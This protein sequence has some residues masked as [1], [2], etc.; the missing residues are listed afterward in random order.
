[1]RLRIGVKDALYGLEKVLL[2][3]YVYDQRC[4][5]EQSIVVLIYLAA[6]E[7]N[8]HVMN[9]SV[10]WQRDLPNAQDRMFILK[11]IDGYRPIIFVENKS[12]YRKII[13]GN[14]DSPGFQ[15]F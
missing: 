10:V 11:S 9:I 3:I 4:F 13:F 7:R 1:M 15:F 5:V 6:L 2:I 8:C 14:D 12:I